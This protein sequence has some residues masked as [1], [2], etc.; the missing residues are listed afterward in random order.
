MKRVLDIICSLVGV[1]VLLPFF[2]VI[3][4]WIFLDDFHSPFFVQERIG[5]FGKPFGL[6]KFRSMRVNSSQKVQITVGRDARIT[7]VGHFIRRYKVDELPQLI[8]VFKGDMSLV[9]PRPEVAKYVN[10]YSEEQKV[11]LQV[12]P[13][14]TDYASLEYFEESELLAK[15]EDPEKTY[16]EEIMPA[17]ININLKYIPKASVKEDIKII[18]LTLKRIAS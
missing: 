13:G 11:V 9:G 14:I 3:G 7:K 16:I 6:L 18:F 1:I 10:L 5:Q 2:V 4:L 8:N 17:K 12:K 15:S